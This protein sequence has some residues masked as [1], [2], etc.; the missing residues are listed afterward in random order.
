MVDP[1]KYEEINRAI[2]TYGTTGDKG[3]LDSYS[4]D[5]I[6]KAKSI[7]R[8]NATQPWF[9]KY[10]EVLEEREKL[11]GQQIEIH[12]HYRGIAIGYTATVVT[13][14]TLEIG[15]LVSHVVIKDQGGGI[16]NWKVCLALFALAVLIF[17]VLVSV[18]SQFYIFKGYFSEARGN[19][20]KANQ[21]YFSPADKMM[22]HILYAFLA[23][24]ASTLIEPSGSF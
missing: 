20:S 22:R 4:T 8:A 13:L 1:K 16:P 15:F 2:K 17:S 11:I 3:N 18:L 5:D 24:T 23:G 19:T 9:S 12:K 6:K 10:D 7:H 14:S 21:R